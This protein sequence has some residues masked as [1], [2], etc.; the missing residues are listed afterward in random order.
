ML[1]LLE[2]KRPIRKTT[3]PQG[4]PRVSAFDV[5]GAIIGQPDSHSR[6]IFHRLRDAHPE[7]ATICS[8]AKFQGK[9]AT[10]VVEVRNLPLFAALLPSAAAAFRKELLEFAPEAADE[11]LDAGAILRERGCSQEQTSRLAPELGKDMWL[12]ASSEG[13]EI[14]TAD[15]QFGP[16]I[17]AVKQYHRVT[18]AKLIHDVFDS[19]RKRPLW[20]RVAADDA[21]TIQRHQLLADRGRGRKKQRIA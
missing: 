20:Q 3:E 4:S 16:E 2:S 21:V 18:D 17:R 13:R 14:T 1:R 10:P 15:M 6:V 9:R 7:I 12:V 8:H 19:F 5:L 11:F